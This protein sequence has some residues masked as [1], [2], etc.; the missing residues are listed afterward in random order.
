MNFTL[1]VLAKA[2]ASINMKAVPILAIDPGREKCG[3]A[4]VEG[5]GSLLWC[6]IWT[7]IELKTRLQVTCSTRDYRCRQRHGF[8]RNCGTSQRSLAANR[9]ADYRRTRLDAGSTR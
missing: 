3:V 6:E 9:S 5:D 8:A 7:R 4:A 2:D 1:Q